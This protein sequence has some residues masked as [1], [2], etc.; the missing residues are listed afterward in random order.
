MDT[1]GDLGCFSFDYVK[2]ITCGELSTKDL[3]YV[4]WGAEEEIFNRA[5]DTIEAIKAE[6][7][8]RATLK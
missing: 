7:F 5:P 4:L 2:T 3:E 8:E 1:I 6:L